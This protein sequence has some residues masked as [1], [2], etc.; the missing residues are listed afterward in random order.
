VDGII[1]A[2]G[3][4]AAAVVALTIG[5]SVPLRA[6][7]TA[8][9]A[10]TA[11]SSS[12][13]AATTTANEIFDRVQRANADRAA[14]LASYTSTRHY[15]VLE[16]GHP[17]DAEMVVSASFVA[18][19]TKSF[20]TVSTHGVGW[21]HRRVFHGLMDAELD[22]AAG[23]QKVDSSI[24]PANYAAQ[25]MGTEQRNGRDC[26]VLALT[27]KR[28]DKYLFVGKVWI[29]KEDAAIARVEGEP[30]KSPS[31]WIVKAPFVRE[32]QRIGG[33]WLPS[34]DE[35]HSQIR[36][37]GEYIL[38]IQYADYQIVPKGSPGTHDDDA[39]RD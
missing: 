11:A 12:A 18:P 29:D 8:S 23:K 4:A 26:Y 20:K 34:R 16:P 35:T 14:A 15:A 31:F 37:A 27:P 1:R 6:Q 28:R 36:F 9:E 21:I 7:T 2:P 39:R 10:P 17:P 25:L 22:A 30:A 38:E 19:S 13:T 33:F 32:Y 24:S 3:I 5:L